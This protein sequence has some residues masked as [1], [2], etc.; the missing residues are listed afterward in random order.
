MTLL[1]QGLGKLGEALAVS[2][3]ERRGYVILERRYR[4]A[5]GE[6]DIVALDAGTLV[7]V[8]VKA[9]ATAEFGRAAEAVT[10]R[11]QMRLAA[12]AV[13]YLARAG[14]ANRPC[15][16]DVVAIDDVE[17]TPTVTVYRNAFDAAGR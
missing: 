15:R 3:L 9:R 2:E 5:R 6:I 7:F 11:K 17:T 14:G 12:M 1:R 8:E 13:D 16:F 10:R 4:T